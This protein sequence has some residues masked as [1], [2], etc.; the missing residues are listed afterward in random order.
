MR[1]YRWPSS[2]NDPGAPFSIV[3]KDGT[4]YRATTVWVQDNT[5]CF[6]AP[7]GTGGQVSVIS[8]NREDTQR[9]SAAL[10]LAFWLPVEPSTSTS[11]MR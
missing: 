8:V 2:G 10:H 7:D 5:V 11:S 9:A 1:E 4:V 3:L 6:T